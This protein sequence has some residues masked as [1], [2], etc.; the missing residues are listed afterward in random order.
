MCHLCFCSQNSFI[1]SSQEEASDLN[2]GDEDNG[3]AS[4]PTIARS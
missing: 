3:F 2:E 1:M 4:D